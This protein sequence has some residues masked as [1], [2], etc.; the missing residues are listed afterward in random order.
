M[1]A[2][3][4]SDIFSLSNHADF[5][6]MT[7]R[8][9]RFQAKHNAVYREY[10]SYL[11]TDVSGISRVEDI[12]HLPIQF[13]KTHRVVTNPA[14]LPVQEVFRSSGTTGQVRSVHEVVNRE[15]YQQ[16]LLQGFE[17]AYGN[18]QKYAFLGLLPNYLENKQASLIFMVKELM[19]SSGG[20]HNGFFLNN[21]SDLDLTIRLL[22]EENKLYI[23]FGVSYA[24]IDFAQAYQPRIKSGIVLETGGMKGKRKEMT[25]QELHELLRT[26]LNVTAIH[27]E[28]GMTELLSQAYSKG[29]GVFRLPPWMRIAIRDPY[30]PF[31]QLPAGRTG[32]VNVIDLA[33]VYSC[34]FIETQDLGKVDDDGHFQIVGRFDQAEVRGCNLLV[35]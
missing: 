32:G 1:R 24:L 12:P 35:V 22:E 28:Y 9:F 25:K 2:F 10:L 3:D 34:A 5:E 8:L 26:K 18:P 14:G 13:F 15:F 11:R 21:F 17:R 20:K 30:D 31:T 7:L 6:A 19:K 27:S 16:S 23:L 33:N 4:L 29:D